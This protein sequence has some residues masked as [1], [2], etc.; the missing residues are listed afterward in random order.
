MSM[1]TQ[2]LDAVFGQRHRM[3]ADAAECD[4]LDEVLRR[5]D[6]LQEGVVPE[7]DPDAVPVA[8][9][10][11]IGYDVAL[12]DLARVMGIDSDPSRFEQPQLERDRLEQILCERGISLGMTCGEP[13]PDRSC[14]PDR[15]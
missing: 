15:S 11:Q 7:T 13:V 10:R 2:L 3:G 8:L 6:E 5:R 4:A 14:V 9:A 1:Y 12:L